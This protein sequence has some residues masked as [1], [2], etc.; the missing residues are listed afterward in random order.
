M[1]NF[2]NSTYSIKERDMI[3]QAMLVLN[4]SSSIDVSFEVTDSSNTAMGE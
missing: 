3:V 4:T 1:V 2:E